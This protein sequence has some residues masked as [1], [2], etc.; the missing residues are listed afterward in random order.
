M[1]RSGPGIGP[2]APVY[3]IEPE[4]ARPLGRLGAWLRDGTGPWS[5]AEA[6][7]AL[8]LAAAFWLPAAV[9]GGA[10][11]F[12]GAL[13]VALAAYRAVRERRPVRVPVVV[14][15]VVGAY[16]AAAAHAR[17][18]A[19]EDAASFLIRPLIALA[20]ATLVVSAAAR[21]RILLLLLAFIATE[22]PVAAWQAARNV[23]D[24]GRDATIGADGVTGTFGAAQAGVLGL[25]AGAG[26]LLVAGAWLAGRLRGRAALA[27]CVALVSVSIFSST[28]AAV[29]F[30]VAVGT[31]MAVVAASFGPMRPAWRKLGLLVAASCV[32]AVVA[33]AGI[34]ALYPD[35]FVGAIS[36][37]RMAALGGARAF[38]IFEPSTR[39]A[40]RPTGGSA[41]AI[42]GVKLL[43]GR[44]VQM[45]LAVTLSHRDGSGP[46]LFGRGPGSSDLDPR[47]RLAQDVPAPQRTG[48]TAF[49]A[50]LTETG[51]L[52][53][54]A[55]SALLAGWSSSGTGCGVQCA[56]A[57]DRA[58]GAALPGLAALTAGGAA[59]N[60]I[61]DVRAVFDRL[62]AARGAR[63]QRPRR[64]PAAATKVNRP[65]RVLVS[66]C[67]DAV[68]G[69][70]GYG[71]SMSH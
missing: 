53:I 5:A 44:F 45:R 52:G 7:V 49:G 30:A 38:G 12:A 60:Q 26:A 8:L 37:Q 27:A 11:P 6:S 61:L 13:L 25:T 57:S 66:G 19:P 46:A 64:E 47:Y 29:P 63:T 58:L 68:T 9:G 59:M 10:W 56:A 43:P 35:A 17:S 3:E 32:T 16:A 69:G 71:S 21:R 20:V 39:P 33:Y 23:V 51:W 31:W 34:V 40:H 28:R 4:P 55:F 67:G 2:G 14:V 1:T 70:R 48:S 50:T 62:L 36:S 54:A 41:G 42:S 18:L 22:I 15:L 24:Y 65:A